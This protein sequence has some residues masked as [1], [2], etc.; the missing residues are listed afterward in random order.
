MRTLNNSLKTMAFALLLVANTAFAAEYTVNLS[1][2]IDKGFGLTLFGLSDQV[3]PFNI[4]FTVDDTGL[5]TVPA[6]TD[7]DGNQNYSDADYMLFS[8][9]RVS[10]LSVTVGNSTW[11]ASDLATRTLGTT[12]NN[13]AVLISGALTNNSFSKIS[14]K[15][16]NAT[17][18]I[19]T[20]NDL[21]CGSGFCTVS[22]SG[23]AFAA[24]EGDFGTI[25]NTQATIAPVTQSP[26]EQIGNITTTVNSLG[27]SKGNTN[28]LL[29]KLGGAM[30]ALDNQIGRDNNAAKNK[31]Q[32]FINQVTAQ[33]GN[34]I[35]AATADQMIAAAQDTIAL[36]N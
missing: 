34:S 32:A 8:A 11:T 13:Y 2:E 31:L 7:I 36:L 17:N 3:I 33:K 22:G 35:D 25:F 9:S 10:N 19:L 26:E 14:L 5:T 4:S 30:G 24:S 27:L 6:G 18:N 15:L 29:S 28:A 16:Q 20:V 21:V 23:E 1:G 12:G